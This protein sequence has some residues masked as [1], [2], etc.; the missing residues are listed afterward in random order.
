VSLSFDAYTLRAHLAPAALAA[1]PAIVLGLS[2]VPS[3]ENAGSILT[4]AFAAALVVLCGIVRGLGR[5]LEPDLWSSWGGAPTTQLLR[6]RGE[7]GD[8]EQ[9]RRHQL[10]ERVIDEVLPARAQEEA[11]PDGADERYAVATTVLR[12]RTRTGVE[13]KLVAHQNAE[14]GMRR[15]CLGLRPVAIAVAT[16][17]LTVSTI[18]F[19]A[20]DE[21]WHLALP[22]AI[23]ILA[24]VA[25]WFLVNGEWVRAAA[26]LYAVRLMETIETLANAG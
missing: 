5:S 11:N 17:V 2:V 4:F 26:D 9:A 21:A 15:S 23:S 1:A 13:F 6:W 25:W 3:L 10:L 22:A 24:V 8:A 16:A 20:E 14:Y 18:L 19:F 12:Q 7:T